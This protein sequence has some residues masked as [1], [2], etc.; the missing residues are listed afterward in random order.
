MKK[1]RATRAHADRGIR[2]R[3]GCHPLKPW[4]FHVMST[5]Q[6]GERRIFRYIP[7]RQTD[8]GNPY[9]IHNGQVVTVCREFCIS[10]R[11]KKI[12]LRKITSVAEVSPDA[13][14]KWESANV[15][16]G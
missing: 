2:R 12:N 10:A 7:I 14:E 5:P 6:P 8:P 13:T 15:H 9:A 11:V 3:G 16:R 4:S 1:R